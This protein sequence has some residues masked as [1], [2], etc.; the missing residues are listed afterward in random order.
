MIPRTIECP[1]CGK[2]APRVVLNNKERWDCSRC[3]ISWTS[4]MLYIA[5]MVATRATLLAYAGTKKARP[6]IG[7]PPK[8][9]DMSRKAL[10]HLRAKRVEKAGQKRYK[11]A[12]QMAEEID[13]AT[14]QKENEE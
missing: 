9:R 4:R 3:Y 2:D 14:E 8:R 7:P 1:S 13:E 10:E 6:A 12:R 5:G 11:S